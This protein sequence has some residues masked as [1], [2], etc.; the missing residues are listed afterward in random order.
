MPLAQVPSRARDTAAATAKQSMVAA[1]ASLALTTAPLA[2]DRRHDH[3]RI[4]VR[5][6]NP[7]E[8]TRTARARKPERRSLWSRIPIARPVRASLLS[9]SHGAG[10]K[11]E[12]LLLPETELRPQVHRRTDL[13]RFARS[14]H[15]RRRA[16]LLRNQRRN[17]RRRMLQAAPRRRSLQ[18]EQRRSGA[19]IRS[20]RSS[21][22]RRA[23]HRFNLPCQMAGRSL[24]AR[25][26]RP[27]R[28][29]QLLHL[30]RLQRLR[31]RQQPQPR[32]RRSAQ[33]RAPRMRRLV[34]CRL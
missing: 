31:W 6:T 24:M 10:E 11:A 3:R 12:V 4:G 17:Q 9:V 22:S 18:L 1:S 28:A 13:R 19:K 21:G 15:R 8:S 33:A 16:A 27:K 5:S 34:Q 32:S 7:S 25:G 30:W 14:S 29:L 20:R 23:H 2:P 26:P